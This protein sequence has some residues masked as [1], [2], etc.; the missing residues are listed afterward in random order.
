M[1]WLTRSQG[2]NPDGSDRPSTVLDV[3]EVPTRQGNEVVA[4]LCTLDGTFDDTVAAI[5]VD[6]V[7]PPHPAV[8]A[9]WQ[10]DV[11]S[12][13]IISIEVG[14]VTCDVEGD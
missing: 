14:R 1:L 2:N 4:S 10:F 11:A 12:E 13:R 9:A 7:A 5:V 8:N 3:T 6:D